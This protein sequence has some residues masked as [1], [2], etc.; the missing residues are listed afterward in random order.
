[1][2]NVYRATRG[3]KKAL[4]RDAG[5]GTHLYVINNHADGGKSYSEWVVTNKLAFEPGVRMAECPATGAET[6]VSQLLASEREIYSRRPSHLPNRAARVRHD[7][8]NDFAQRAAEEVADRHARDAAETLSR[9]YR[10]LAR[11]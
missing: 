9:R 2:K 6:A 7:A 10:S 11:R 1:M 5:P 3:D 4:F 8:Y